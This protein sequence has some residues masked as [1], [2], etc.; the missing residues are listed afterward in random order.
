LPKLKSKFLLLAQ[1]HHGNKYEYKIGERVFVT[2]KITIV[3]PV[4]GE[5]IQRASV[6]L[7][8]HGCPGCGNESRM[9]SECRYC[10][11]PIRRNHRMTCKDCLTKYEHDKIKRREEKKKTVKCLNCGCKIIKRLKRKFCKESCRL[12]FSER[13][14]QSKTNC[15]CQICGKAI[16]RSNYKINKLKRKAVCSGQ[17][18]NEYRYRNKTWDS[19][20]AKERWKI[21]CRN[22]RERANL[23]VRTA[24]RQLSILIGKSKRLKTGKTWEIKCKT[25]AMVLKKRAGY[26]DLFLPKK[27]ISTWDE[28]VCKA[29]YK[30]KGQTKRQTISDWELKCETTARGIRHRAKR[31]SNEKQSS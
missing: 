21:K 19:K 20:A 23:W 31:S 10:K 9:K 25:A 15:K 28:T 11:K 2:Q 7:Q 30:I 6:H 5:F 3:C 18:E 12:E 8:G 1:K 17:C 27:Q 26:K 14:K 29:I 4:H 16:Y 24:K 22:K 13:K